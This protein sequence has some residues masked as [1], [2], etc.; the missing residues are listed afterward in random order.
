MTIYVLRHEWL[1]E[2]DPAW[3]PWWDD[4]ARGLDQLKRGGLK[5][6]FTDKGFLRVRFREVGLSN[7][8]CWGSRN[9]VALGY[10]QASKVAKRALST[11]KSVPEIAAEE[12]GIDR[13][14]FD[15]YLEKATA[16]GTV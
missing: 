5:I 16:V 2:I 3:Q 13:Q 8:Q 11:G 15:E 12:F 7:S 1:R 14:V 9:H 10:E 6:K 4:F